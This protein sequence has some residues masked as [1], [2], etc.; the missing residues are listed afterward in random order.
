MLGDIV[1]ISRV[2]DMVLHVTILC[3]MSLFLPAIG[4]NDPQKIGPYP[5][6][7]KR[8]NWTSTINPPV[9]RTYSPFFRYENFWTHC[10]LDL[11]SWTWRM[12]SLFDVR[13]AVNPC[14]HHSHDHHILFKFKFRNNYPIANQDFTPGHPGSVLRRTCRQPDSV[15]K[16]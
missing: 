12:Q 9:S 8:G 1:G 2:W 13:N 5:V 16:T 10:M 11:I 15:Q 14:S 6:V 4:W 3:Q 7:M